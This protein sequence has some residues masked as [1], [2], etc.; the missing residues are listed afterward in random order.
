MA[1]DKLAQEQI[2]AGEQQYIEDLANRLKEKIIREN[3]SG[4]MRRDA[5]PKMHGLVKAEFCVEADL[6]AELKVGLFKE[7]GR[8]PAWVRFSNQDPSRQADIKRDI[9]GM[10]VKVMGVAGKKLLENESDAPTQDFLT[11]S[12]PYFVT[13]DPKEFDELVIACGKGGLSMIWFFLSHLRVTYNLLSSN[14]KFANPLQITYHSTT[15][16]L[17]GEGR[18]VKYC[19]A[20]RLT[21]ADSIPSNPG[22]DYL[23]EAMQKQLSQGEAVFDF[24]VQFQTDARAMPIEDPGVKWDQKLSPF[25]KVATIRIPQQAFDSQARRE[26]GENLSFTPWH[27][28]PEHRPLGGVNRARKMVYDF[29]SRFRHEKNGEKRGEPGGF[30]V[31]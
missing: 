13:H 29:I 23:R 17:F 14:R 10:A 12:T 15:P 8:W 5:H 21:I 16:Y 11:I 2:A 7:A 24:M 25:R 19:V 22:P 31:E 6:P 3:P 1:T 20:P 9:R 4:I 27:S 28:L 18:A 30:E 26:Y